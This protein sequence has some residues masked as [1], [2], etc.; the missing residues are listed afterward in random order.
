MW[1]LRIKIEY[2]NCRDCTCK[3]W[4]LWRHFK[5]Q[6]HQGLRF[7]S[8][9]TITINLTP[10]RLLISYCV[11][12][13]VRTIVF[14]KQILL[15]STLC[16]NGHIDMSCDIFVQW[17]SFKQIWMRR[18]HPYVISWRIFWYMGC[19]ERTGCHL[20]DEKMRVRWMAFKEAF[21]WLVS[22]DKPLEVFS[23]LCIS[24]FFLVYVCVVEERS[25]SHKFNN[26]FY[27]ITY[28]LPPH[29]YRPGPGPPRQFSTPL[30][31]Q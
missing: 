7:S 2:C 22:W 4:R 5:L 21:V 18:L 20:L 14:E 31:Y 24:P 28:R 29:S 6:W 10:Q 12:F 30:W 1:W 16:T 13:C 19:T 23:M 26:S 15:A 27:T 9:R 11:A 8:C 25:L 17:I 3:M